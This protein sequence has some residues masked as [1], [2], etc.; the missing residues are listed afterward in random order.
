MTIKDILN[1]SN[2]DVMKLTKEEL[3]PLVR[4][5]V[6]VTRKRIKRIETAGISSPA[7]T[8]VRDFTFSSSKKQN[9]NQLRQQFIKS[10][11]FL[12]NKTSTLKGARQARKKMLK[13]LNIEEEIPQDEEA[14][15][16]SAMNRLQD[17][18]PEL[19]VGAH[20]FT[21]VSSIVR[22]EIRTQKKPTYTK[23]KNKLIK[24]VEEEAEIIASPFDFEEDD[25]WWS[26]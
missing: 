12:K 3:Q 25:E 2:E 22:N 16:W 5:T 9:L 20:S 26:E 13:T 19:F 18:K 7:V 6:G 10:T 11:S 8:N 17:E 24:Y 15:F 21:N 1:L 23:I 14:L 4:Q